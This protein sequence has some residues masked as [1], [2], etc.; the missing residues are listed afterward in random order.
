MNST[1]VNSLGLFLDIVGA[2]LLIKFGIP[3]KIDREGH[4]HLILEQVDESEIAR[5]K[6]FDR[7]STFAISLIVAGFVLQLVSNYI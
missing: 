7:W 6:T 5:A 3:P 2:L 1:F 4:Q